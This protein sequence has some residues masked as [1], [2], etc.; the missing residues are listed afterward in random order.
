MKA[1]IIGLVFGITVGVVMWII[2]WIAGSLFGPS[3]YYQAP[4]MER[5]KAVV[6]AYTSSV[7]ET[8]DTPHITASGERTRKGIV[9]N[10]CLEFGTKV[11]IGGKEY[12]V[13]DRLN[14]RYGCE[15]YDIWV[16]TKGEA[17]EWGR[18]E[19]SVAIRK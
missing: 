17:F 8:D 19:L 15:H 7:E 4:E 18:R 16:E 9:A 5:M 1:A 2:A 10:N 6:M 11:V 13:Q 12:E 14:K 3:V